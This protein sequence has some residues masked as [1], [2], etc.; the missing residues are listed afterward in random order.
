MKKGDKFLN[1]STRRTVTY[2]GKYKESGSGKTVINYTHPGAPTE[3][4]A[5]YEDDFKKYYKPKNKN[6]ELT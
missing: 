2:N 3:V 5:L 1:R 6:N 4:G